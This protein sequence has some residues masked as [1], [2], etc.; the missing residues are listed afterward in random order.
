[1]SSLSVKHKKGNI[2]DGDDDDET[3]D[4]KKPLIL[5]ILDHDYSCKV[6]DN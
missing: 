2:K 1:M 4:H 3:S 5:A 6:T